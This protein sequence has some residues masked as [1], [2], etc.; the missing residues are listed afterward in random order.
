MDAADIPIRVGAPGDWDA[1]WNLLGQLF[2]S[3]PSDEARALEGAVFEPARSLIAEDA[4]ALVGHV[5]A[6]TRNLTVPG[7]VVPAAHISGVGVAPT[8]R[9]RGLLTRMMHRQLRDI[10][11][12]EEPIAVLWASETKIYPRFGYGPASQRLRLDI[13]TR[14]VRLP[15]TRPDGRLR[16]VDPVEAIPVFSKLYDDL[17][18]DRVGWSTRDDA[19]WK[20]TLADVESQRGGATQLYGVVHET[21]EGPDGYA[22]WRTKDDWNN[23]GPNCQVQIREL[24]AA[25]P[26]AYLALWRFLLTIDLTRSASMHLAALDEPLQYLVDEPRRLGAT[27]ADGLW[28]RIV[29]LPRALTARR[30]PAPLDVVLEVTD[31][32]L[33][34]NSGR[35]RLTADTTGNA[36][37]TPTADPADLSCTV[38]E[39]GT[40]YLGAVSLAALQA[41]GTVHELTPGAVRRATAAFRWHRMPQPTD[42]F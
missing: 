25:N 5:A 15:D 37:C 1:I 30:Y 35:W 16:Q 28:I 21:P 32:L 34:A 41:A 18:A 19:W 33:P 8:H 27:L 36:T 29:D 20:F 11:A 42:L 24:V 10:A 9:R 31:P 3:P 23:L 2:H 7:A 39:L 40:V 13:S 22:T 12:G 38:L 17:R 4:G 6:Y 26:E 14:E